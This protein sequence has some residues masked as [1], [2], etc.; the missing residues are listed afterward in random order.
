MAE[1]AVGGVEL[2]QV[3]QR[4]GVRQI[5]DCHDIQIVSLQGAARERTA[6]TAEAINS[7]RI[8]IVASFSMSV[9]SWRGEPAP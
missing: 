6:D 7:T 1:S 3:R 5:I 2:Q 4:A 9:G 8:A